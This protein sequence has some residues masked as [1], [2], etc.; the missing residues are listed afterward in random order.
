[1][2][3]IETITYFKVGNREFDTEEEA[4]EYI[5][6]NTFSKDELILW[7]DEGNELD[8][9]DEAENRF[10]ST[11][12]I[13]IKSASAEKYFTEYNKRRRTYFPEKIG[14]YKYADSANWWVSYEMIERDFKE[15]W[16]KFLR[17]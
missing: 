3:K 4:Q 15:E 14:L 12:Y 6:N 7:D 2:L 9:Y 8:F 17:S 13:K 16:D 11:Y 5:D 10:I 1:M